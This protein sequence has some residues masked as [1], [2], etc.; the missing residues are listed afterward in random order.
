MLKYTLED[1]SVGCM[2]YNGRMK[3]L[4]ITHPF[5][6]ELAQLQFCP[7]CGTA[8]GSL[9]DLYYAKYDEYVDDYELL[10]NKDEF[11][12]HWPIIAQGLPL[13]ETMRLIDEARGRAAGDG[14]PD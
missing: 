7:W 8:T 6:G 14:P 4:I 13:A 2:Q 5:G 10:E 3:E 9:I 12:E 1:N 11:D